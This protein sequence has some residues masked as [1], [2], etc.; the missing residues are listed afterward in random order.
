MNID[1]NTS[2]ILLIYRHPFTANAPT[3]MEHVN[4]LAKYSRHRIWPVNSKYGFPRGLKNIKFSAIVL[5]YSVFPIAVSKKFTKFYQY[6]ESIPNTPKIAFFQDEHW[7]CIQRFNFINSIGIDTIYSLLEPQH[8]Q[9]VYRTHTKCKT[10]KH[11]L[12]G[13]VDNSLIKLANSTSKPDLN[14]AIDIGYRAR[15]LP[16]HWGKGGQEKTMIADEFVRRVGSSNLKID[17]ETAEAKRIYG[18]SWHH[19]IADCRAMIGVEAGVSIFDIEG[20]VQSACE[21]FLCKYPHATF[22]EIHAS[23][24][25]PWENNI[26]YRTISPRVFEC[27]AF[28]VCMILFEG[29]YSGILKP[30]IH[31][32]PLKKDFS[33]FEQVLDIFNDPKERN[34]LTHNSYR[35]LID[36]G[37]YSYQNFVRD[38]DKELE[39]MGIDYKIDDNKIKHVTECL[40]KDEWLRIPA[41]NI[42]RKLRKLRKYFRSRNLSE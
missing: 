12:P 17:I 23:L 10:I 7:G 6:L 14:R 16:F 3:I 42:S 2:G 5:H 36:S 26:Y 19:F 13:Y 28:K 39:Q 21:Q 37:I 32:I 8:H 41:V 9:E 20:K 27:A 1:D 22:D 30:M 35:D 29:S 11:T 25:L 15:P 38:F 33:N 24:L 4:S 31:Y 34:R 40:Q 18:S